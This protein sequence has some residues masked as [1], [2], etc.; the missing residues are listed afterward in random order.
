VWS[1]YFQPGQTDTGCLQPSRGS[2]V[3]RNSASVVKLRNK[4][5]GVLCVGTLVALRMIIH[6]L[7]NKI[8]HLTTHS[9]FFRPR[10]THLFRAPSCLIGNMAVAVAF[11]FHMKKNSKFQNLRLFTKNVNLRKSGNK[12]IHL[13]KN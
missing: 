5:A 13:N 7:R 12:C 6:N 11:S 3:R 10:H 2:S 1:K 9:L 4:Y 8:P